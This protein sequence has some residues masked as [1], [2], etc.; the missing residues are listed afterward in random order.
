MAQMTHLASFGPILIIPNPLCL[1]KL[2]SCRVGG[3]LVVTDY[4]VVM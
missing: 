3:G 1:F 2:T 4:P